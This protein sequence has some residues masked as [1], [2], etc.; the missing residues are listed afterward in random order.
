[1]SQVERP[2][3]AGLPRELS[4]EA[5]ARIEAELPAVAGERYDDAGMASVNL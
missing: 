1:V 5:L 3:A 2:T 4:A